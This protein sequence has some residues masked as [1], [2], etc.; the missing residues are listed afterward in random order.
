L[1]WTLY[2]LCQ[3]PPDQQKIQAESENPDHPYTRAVIN[4]SLRLF[5]P[6]F[7]IIREAVNPDRIGAVSIPARAVIMI[8]PWVLHRHHAFWQDPDRFDPTRFSADQP[9]LVRFS[10]LPFGA[11][12]RVCVGAQFA[13]ME[14]TLVISSLLKHFSISCDRSTDVMPVGIVTTQPD[15]PL[16]A[17]FQRRAD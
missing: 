8:A 13:L 7:T 3:S 15:R 17:T 11:G 10:Y 5:P 16:L 9:A 6:A 4:E 14:A 2:L 1:F 12:P